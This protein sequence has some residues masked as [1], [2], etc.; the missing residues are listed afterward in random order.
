MPP[1]RDPFVQMGRATAQMDLTGIYRAALSPGDPQNTLRNFTGL[2]RNYCDT[3]V[4]RLEMDGPRAARITVREFEGVSREMCKIV[5]GYIEG[6]VV[7]AGGKG[8]VVRKTSCLL[9][10]DGACSWTIS[11]AG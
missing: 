11:W 2:W 1:G 4:S 9:D 10:G 5:G 7:V 6:L 8:E 3:G